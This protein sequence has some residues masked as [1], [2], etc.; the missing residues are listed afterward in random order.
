MGN[1]RVEFHGRWEG[2]YPIT[3]IEFT[4]TSPCLIFDE[5]GRMIYGYIEGGPEQ[6]GNYQKLAK[7]LIYYISKSASYSLWDN[8]HAIAIH[9]AAEA[10]VH[11]VD[12]S[13]IETAQIL[14][15]KGT[16]I[17]SIFLLRMGREIFDMSAAI[18][19]WYFNSSWSKRALAVIDR[20][21]QR[22]CHLALHPYVFPYCR[23]FLENA[24]PSVFRPLLHPKFHPLIHRAIDIVFFVRRWLARH[25]TAEIVLVV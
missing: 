14:L 5:R 24:V 13:R 23:G 3:R 7:G 4:Q 8:K 19:V 17:A 1:Y 6:A 22:L 21:Y 11:T 25:Q 20:C 15:E 16:S 2:P 18:L 10:L 12:K 9:L